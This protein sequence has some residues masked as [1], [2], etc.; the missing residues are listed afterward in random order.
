M[1]GLRDALLARDETRL[2]GRR[3]EDWRWTDLRGT[4]RPLPAVSDAV[5]PL[6]ARPA[7]EGV[8]LRRFAAPVTAGVAEASLSVAA[9][10]TLVLLDVIEAGQG[11]YARDLT[12]HITLGEGATLHRLVLAADG[13]EAVSVSLTQVTLAPGA[14][15]HQTVLA[16]GA[17]RQR[18]ATTVA[19]PGAGARAGVA[20]GRRPAPADERAPWEAGGRQIRWI[21][22]PA[23]L[24]TSLP[25]TG[26][27]VPP[28]R[29]RSRRRRRRRRLGAG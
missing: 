2:P 15:F 28:Q 29:G 3:D 10:E 24:I 7:P 19:H 9:G 4:L 20:V 16:T 5:Q 21:T 14:T 27:H 23:G 25:H 18:I 11:T 17:R 1:T 6:A 26:D 12:L 8:Q 22:S 13:A